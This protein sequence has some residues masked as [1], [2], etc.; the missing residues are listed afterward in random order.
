LKNLILPVLAGIMFSSS[1]YSAD[2]YLGNQVA[3]ASSAYDW[4]GFYVGANA[5][6]G[7]GDFKHPISIGMQLADDFGDLFY[8]SDDFEGFKDEVG[9]LGGVFDDMTWGEVSDGEYDGKSFTLGTGTLDLTAAGFVGGVQAGY[10]FMATENFLLGIEA[11]IQGSSIKGEVSAS[12]TDPDFNL[13]TAGTS[14]DWYGTLRARAG[15]AQDRFLAYV[16]GG[17]AYGQTTSSISFIDTYEGS[18][19]L[20]RV[21]WTVGAGVEYALTDNISLKTEYSY[22]DLGTEDVL[23]GSYPQ[24]YFD[25]EGSL[26]SNVAFHTVKAGLNFHF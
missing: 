25:L 19:Q 15:Y 2:L 17:L 10:N 23:S 6:Y 5:G 1:A 24:D 22:V 18:V 11:D 20:D 12:V 3:A 9:Y 14:L 13:V 21:G 26:G 16:T 4:S 7:G 8:D